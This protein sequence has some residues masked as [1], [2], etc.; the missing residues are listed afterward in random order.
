MAPNNEVSTIEYYG[1]DTINK[2]KVQ[3]FIRSAVNSLMG[4]RI[5]N[6]TDP[7]EFVIKTFDTRPLVELLIY[8]S[9][10]PVFDKEFASSMNYDLDML[11]TVKKLKYYNNLPIAQNLQLIQQLMLSYGVENQ[12]YDKAYYHLVKN[13]GK[14]AATR[15]NDYVRQNADKMVNG[16]TYIDNTA[17]LEKVDPHA[18]YPTSI[19][20]HCDGLTLASKDSKSIE[21]VMSTTL[22]TSIKITNN[23]L[24]FDNR[25][26][27]NVYLPL[28]RCVAIIDDKVIKYYGEKL[29]AYFDHFGVELIKLVHGGDEIDKDIKNVEK[30]LVELKA[31]GVS[32]H[33]PV[34]I[35]GGG[36]IAD[37]GGFATAL[38]HRNT[39][40]VM[41]CTS[42]VTGIDA[43]PSPRTCCDGFGFKNLYGAYHPPILT[44]TDRS[45]FRSLHEGWLRH[46]IAEIIKM[47]V[48]KDKSLF[49][50][51][52]KAGPRLI[53]TKFGTVG[54]TDAEFEE[55]CDLII[56]KAMEGYVRSEY[57]NL[58]E[59][60]Q[61]RP[62]A[63]GHTWS[64]GYELPAG[65]LHGHAVATC[66][67]YGAYLARLE[68]FI[69]ESEQ[70]RILKLISDMELS[71]WHDIMENHDLVAAANKK[72]VEKRG[73]NLCAPVPKQL[74]KCGYINELSREKLDTTLDDY[75]NICKSFPRGGRGIDVHC[76][77]VGLQDPST[78]AGDAYQGISKVIA[79]T[80]AEDAANKPGSY[81]EW[82]KNV[83]TERNNEWEMNVTF[84]QSADTEC[85][86]DFNNFK[87]FHDGVERYAMDQ[88]TVASKDMQY[89]AGLTE[90]N[91]MFSPCM[92][93]TLESQFLKMQCQIK[94]AKT[95]LDV[96]TFT[97]MS[98]LAFAEGIPKDGKVVTLECY[99]DI[100]KVAQTAFDAS[101]V[102]HKI[103]LRVGKAIES[104]KQLAMEGQ[105]FDIIFL[106]ADKENY[107]AYYDLALNE[108]LLANDGIIM[109]DNVLCALLYDKSD[110]RSQKLH[111][112]NQYV[113][114]DPRVEQVQ[115]TIR[116]GISII[117]RVSDLD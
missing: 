111:E 103:D 9:R 109:A 45:F 10:L 15:F 8:L 27:I 106:D 23:V 97:G 68:G 79:N 70:M 64:P 2:G 84:Q 26:L 66:M 78:V 56:G 113:K 16:S 108:G 47:A 38:Y 91:K 54:D 96:G 28:G 73:G 12:D 90:N 40:Y 53:T 46:G 88:T 51:L 36:V 76:R 87:L 62:H 99:D 82:I 18:V 105:K 74:G 24:D 48:V 102:G 93:G 31:K 3:D 89:I 116:E 59:T 98:A 60:H 115:L 50:L 92:V 5:N 22:T 58:W 117:R 71:L 37:I 101:S 85:P 86:P 14:F 63:Y 107:Q 61:C 80:T 4:K 110:F 94:G 19:Y 33:E 57:G 30:I 21:A 43:G 69:T 42:I 114:N 83:Q 32:R 34:L 29:Q 75:K 13:A 49:E 112:F 25:H 17:T 55:M 72:V 41:L 1:L 7:M 11:A 67:G 6:D 65:M 44:L 104:M 52:E 39:P 20:R 100:A 95:C 35:M 81:A 77:D